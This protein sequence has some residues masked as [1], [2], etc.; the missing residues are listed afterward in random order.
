MKYLL[1]ALLLASIAGVEFFHELA[2][3][4]A[5][6]V[7]ACM[8]PEGKSAVIRDALLAHLRSH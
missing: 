4:D 8:A 7:M 5:P 2:S 6:G 1:I 3:D